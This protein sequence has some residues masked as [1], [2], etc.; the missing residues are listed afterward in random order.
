M[1]N[2]TKERMDRLEKAMLFAL[3]SLCP[4]G[5]SGTPS[6]CWKPLQTLLSGLCDDSIREIPA[7]SWT[8]EYVPKGEEGINVEIEQIL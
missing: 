3:Y 8:V 6:E 7:G 1:T 2:Q 5:A 4:T